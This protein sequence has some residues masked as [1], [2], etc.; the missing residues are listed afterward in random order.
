MDIR[1]RMREAAVAQYQLVH[2]ENADDRLAEFDLNVAEVHDHVVRAGL[3]A[4]SSVSPLAPPGAAGRHAHDGYAAGLRGL[5]IPRGWEI[6]QKDMVARTVHR[7]RRLAILISGGNEFTAMLGGANYLTS[8]WPK[9][10]RALAGAILP[11]QDGFEAVDSSDFNWGSSAHDDPEWV[12]WYLLHYHTA[13]EV[14]LELS[15]PTRL[16]DRGFPRGWTNR[17][18]LPPYILGQVQI[19]DD[20]DDD[21]IGG[22]PDV[23]VI[24]R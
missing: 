7:Q 21:D 15:A 3:Q 20:Q 8:A 18:I 19:D 5:L 11:R 6:E 16:D 17:I 12:V 13:T 1:Y 24:P 23:P 2:P 9:G 14:R 22:E 4:A 10:N